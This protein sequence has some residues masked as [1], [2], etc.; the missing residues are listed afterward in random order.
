LVKDTT[1]Y[2]QEGL[3]QLEFRFQI[4]WFCKHDLK[5]M[6]LQHASQVSSRWPYAHDKF[7]DEVFTENSQYWDEVVA[8]MVDPKMTRLGAMI[9]DEHAVNIEKSTQEAHRSR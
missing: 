8:R 9:L 1:Q 2:R 4:G 5:G 7:E 3:R 6:V